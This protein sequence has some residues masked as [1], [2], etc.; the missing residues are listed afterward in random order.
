VKYSSEYIT[1]SSTLSFGIKLID[2][3]HKEF[4]DLVN[5]MY[6]H[7]TGNNKKEHEY[8]SKV[9]QKA[10][11]LL[12]VHFATEEKLMSAIHYPDYAEHKRNHECFIL[13]V[14]INIRNFE[15]DKHYSLYS[16][17]KFLKDC[18][19]SHIGVMDKQYHLYIKKMIAIRNAN[20]IM[21]VT[22]EK[23]NIET[24]IDALKVPVA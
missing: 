19:L 12:Q 18:V 23:S 4:I 1:W 14:V 2:D 5:E 13:D 21:I 10:V 17:T 8:F 3:Q 11:H 22:P 20:G 6:L 16:F 15:T 9:I 24:I 7:A